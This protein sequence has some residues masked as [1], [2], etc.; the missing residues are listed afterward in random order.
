M[1]EK[2]ISCIYPDNVKVRKIETW[3]DGATVVE[4]YKGQEAGRQGCFGKPLNIWLC[5][6]SKP[7]PNW[8]YWLSSLSW[9]L[10]CLGALLD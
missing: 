7:L 8:F 4:G 2:I 5:P 10:N 6:V 1:M 3:E 9:K